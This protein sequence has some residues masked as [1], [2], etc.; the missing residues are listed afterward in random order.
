MQLR[1]A[2]SYSLAQVKMAMIK[3]STDNNC[4]NGVKKRGRFYRGAEMSKGNS[5]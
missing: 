3:K 1:T 5:H 2:M 4:Y